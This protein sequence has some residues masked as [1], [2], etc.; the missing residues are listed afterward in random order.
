[1]QVDPLVALEADQARLGGGGEGTSDLGLADAGL[2]LEQ[3]WLLEGNREMYRQRERTTGQITLGGERRARL[4][5][6]PDVRKSHTVIMAAPL[7]LRGRGG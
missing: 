3:E 4:L 1:M 5:Y 2:A 6:G 7:P